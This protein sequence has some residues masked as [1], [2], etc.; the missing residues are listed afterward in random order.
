MGEVFP[1]WIL[2]LN[3]ADFLFSAPAFDFLLA[4]DGV[5]DVGEVFEVDQAKDSVLGGEPGDQA[6]AVL[7]HAFVEVA[8]DAGVEITRTAGQDVDGVGAG[9]G[10]F[11]LR[12]YAA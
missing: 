12:Q 6:L 11:L 4:G 10:R 3:Q 9:H 8:G 7:E 1:R 5:P 2:A